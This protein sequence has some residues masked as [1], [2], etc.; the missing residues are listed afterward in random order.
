MPKELRTGLRGEATLVVSAQDTA[1]A[2]GSGTVDVLGTPVL[3]ALMERAAVASLAPV[4]PADQ[5][6]V[7][8][9]I[10]VRH[11]APTPPGMRV[12]AQATLIEIDGRRLRFRVTAQDEVETIAEGE[13]TRV[14]VNVERFL[15]RVQAKQ[16]R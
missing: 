7:G 12:T 8:T 14:L 6:S 10:H 13:H 3:I 2:V 5:T 1:Q 16:G 11:I 9:E 4:L 15:D